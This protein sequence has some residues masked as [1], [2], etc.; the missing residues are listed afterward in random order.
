MLKS[1]PTP[2]AVLLPILSISLSCG[3]SLSCESPAQ[4]AEPSDRGTVQTAPAVRHDSPAATR[5][6][7]Q[8]STGDQTTSAQA[9]ALAQPA[10]ATQS[11]PGAQTNSTAQTNSGAQPSAGAQ[12]SGSGQN[13]PNPGASSGSTGQVGGQQ[14]P[15]QMLNQLLAAPAPAAKPLVTPPHDPAVDKTSGKGAVAPN[16]PVVHVLREGSSIVDRIGRL[17]HSADGKQAEFTFESDGKTMQDPPLIILPN[18]KLM[19]MEGANAGSNRDLK[20]RVTGL[21]TEYRG[22]NYLLLEKVLVLSDTVDQF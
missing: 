13:G 21:I 22:R 2:R 20:F 16:A 9:D 11:P 14:T 15:E 5:P 19:T 1:L 10:A 6:A 8:P 3:L 17:T 12:S 18:L 7:T 4:S